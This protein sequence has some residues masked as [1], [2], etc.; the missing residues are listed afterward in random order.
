MIKKTKEP[1]LKGEKVGH[2]ISA[3]L[4]ADLK[5]Y[6]GA[7]E[8]GLISVE[9]GVGFHTVDKLIQGYNSITR[10]NMIAVLRAVEMAAE[11]SKQ[12][13]DDSKKANKRLKLKIK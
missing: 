2:P 5:K 8:R 12:E 7:A 10:S 4:S 6:L 13:A 1:S 3:E 11:K 9:T